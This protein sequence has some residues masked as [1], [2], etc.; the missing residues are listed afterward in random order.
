MVS[1]YPHTL[2]TTIL[3]ADAVQDGNGN[4]V[5]PAIEPTTISQAC[6]AEPNGNSFITL[7]D[8]SK[9][10]YAFVVYMPLSAPDIP[11]DATVTITGVITA[12]VKQFYRGQL[13]CRLWL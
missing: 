10:S 5:Q 6:R 8:G 7:M 1:Q 9:Y 4:W 2:T 13:N 3:S 11:S 12:T